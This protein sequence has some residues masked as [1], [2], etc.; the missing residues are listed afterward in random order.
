MKVRDDPACSR[1]TA[2]I[3]SHVLLRNGR[4]FKLM[5]S[6]ALV[7]HKHPCDVTVEEPFMAGRTHVPFRV[8]MQVVVPVFG[9]PSQHALLGAALSEEGKNEL[10]NTTC[11]KRSVREIAMATRRHR[12]SLEYVIEH[13]RRYRRGSIVGIRWSW[14]R[15]VHDLGLTG[16][17]Q[18]SQVLS[19]GNGH[20][21]AE[22]SMARPLDVAV[23]MPF[24][25]LH[26]SNPV[27]NRPGRR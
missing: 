13:P 16:V 10:E 14:R 18:S 24:C 11:R 6:H 4:D 2:A 22:P 25:G 19:R 26:G 5:N 15:H 12:F 27:I 21:V 1:D 8:G 3:R 23:R 20:V 17:D 7:I 9:S